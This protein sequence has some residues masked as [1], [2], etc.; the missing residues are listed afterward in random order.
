MPLSKCLL[1]C[2]AT[3][4]VRLLVGCR[5]LE[6]IVPHT[7]PFVSESSECKS[8]LF[9]EVLGWES[10]S[11]SES[12][13]RSYVSLSLAV[14]RSLFSVPVCEKSRARA[15]SAALLPDTWRL[16]CLRWILICLAVRD[17][18]SFCSFQLISGRVLRSASLFWA[19]NARNSRCWIRLKAKWVILLWPP[20]HLGSPPPHLLIIIAQS[21]TTDRR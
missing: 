5:R 8:E 19:F 14:F 3:V 7:K 10:E 6:Q 13:D 9:S 4:S 12:L 20:P 16:F 1:Y 15:N 11:Y 18:T 17:L 21:L 2:H